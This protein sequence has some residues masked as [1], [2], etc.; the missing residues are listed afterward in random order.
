MLSCCCLHGVQMSRGSG[1]CCSGGGE[2]KREG[3]VKSET[4]TWPEFSSPIIALRSPLTPSPRIQIDGGVIVKSIAWEYLLTPWSKRP[5]GAIL[6]LSDSRS[7][8]GDPV[9]LQRW[10]FLE[11][12]N[13]NPSSWPLVFANEVH[14]NRP[15]HS[16]TVVLGSSLE[17]S[18]GGEL[19]MRMQSIQRHKRQQKCL[20]VMGKVNGLE[21]WL[22]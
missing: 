4:G 7:H 20:L 2:T 16:R 11:E 12:E 22:A 15:A 6:H 18:S 5:Q 9:L 3:G 21:N 13:G 19:F 8:L 10:L 1:E 17:D 14:Q